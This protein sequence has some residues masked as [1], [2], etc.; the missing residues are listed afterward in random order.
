MIIY[1][2]YLLENGVVREK[3]SWLLNGRDLYLD[4]DQSQQDISDVDSF[5]DA[6]ADKDSFQGAK[7]L[8]PLRK[9]DAVDVSIMQSSTPSTTNPVKEYRESRIKKLENKFKLATL[10]EQDEEDSFVEEALDQVSNQSTSGSLGEETSLA[11]SCVNLDV[12]LEEDED[13][14]T[15]DN[16]LRPKLDR[17]ADATETTFGRLSE[18]NPKAKTAADNHALKSVVD[19]EE[20]A[21]EKRKPSF[22]RGILSKTK[23]SLKKSDLK[24]PSSSSSKQTTTSLFSGRSVSDSGTLSTKTPLLTRIYN[25]IGKPKAAAN[26]TVNNERFQLDYSQLKKLFNELEDGEFN[27]DIDAQRQLKKFLQKYKASL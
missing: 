3:V 25:S 9:W 26:T 5:L 16:K 1:N 7:E 24:I 20:Q 19:L 6:A 23:D 8:P 11:Q 21:K 27:D 12:I 10:E 18:I 13:E 14:W 22:L 17:N 2:I 15:D 4:D